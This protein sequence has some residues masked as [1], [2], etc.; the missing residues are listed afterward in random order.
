MEGFREFRVRWWV[1]QSCMAL[2]TGFV[3]GYLASPFLAFLVPVPF[4]G[5]IVGA[6]CGF[7]VFQASALK[8]LW[9]GHC[10]AM[11][12][13]HREEQIDDLIAGIRLTPGNITCDPLE[14]QYSGT[15]AFLNIL[16][17]Q[18]SRTDEEKFII[19]MA[20][21][22]Q[23]TRLGEDN[24]S[25]ELLQQAVQLKPQHLVANFRLAEAY[26]RIGAG[27]E[28]IEAYRSALADPMIESQ[29]LKTFV[30]SQIE[31]VKTKG[32]NQ[33]SQYYGLRNLGA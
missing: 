20:A 30:T 11:E 18:R 16:K 8:Q 28:A 26:E 12:Y 23:A 27:K 19:Y 25:V 9:T 33:R 29:A 10:G 32:P 7:V 1:K 14:L 4:G 31:R 15:E 5:A 21:A 2:A 22:Y 6:I 24:K 17:D 3:L 13:T